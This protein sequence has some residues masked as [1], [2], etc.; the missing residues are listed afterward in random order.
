MLNLY[1]IYKAYAQRVLRNPDNSELRDIK[2]IMKYLIIQSLEGKFTIDEQLDCA[3]KIG[4]IESNQKNFKKAYYLE[5]QDALIDGTYVIEIP[6]QVI[7]RWSESENSW[8]YIYLATSEYRENQVKLGATTIPIWRREAAYQ[9]RWG[10]EIS[11]DWKIWTNQPLAKEHTIKSRIRENLVS[12][13][14]NGESNEWYYGDLTDFTQ[15]IIE[16]C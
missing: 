16:E 4:I 8:G 1:T 10:Y 14:T 13:L 7:N 9:K 3:T 15:I 2:E 6:Y 11:I 12:G 5:L